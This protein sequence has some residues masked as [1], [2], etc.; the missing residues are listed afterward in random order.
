MWP[1]P[2]LPNSAA[3]FIHDGFILQQRVTAMVIESRKNARLLEAGQ[4]GIEEGIFSCEGS[5]RFRFSVK[6]FSTA[7]EK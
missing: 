7:A 5:F 1:N 6:I 2:V 3:S 4:L